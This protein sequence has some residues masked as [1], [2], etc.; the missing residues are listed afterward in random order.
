MNLWTLA[1]LVLLSMAATLALQL[2]TLKHLENEFRR[3]TRFLNGRIEM[4]QQDIIDGIVAQLTKAKNEIVGKLEE[5]T[6][7]VQAQLV[8]AGV[9]DQVDLSALTGIAQALDDLVPDAEVE[10]VVEAVAVETA[11]EAVDEVAVDPVAVDEVAVDPVAVA[12]DEVAVD[13]VAVDE[14]AVDPAE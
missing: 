10:A 3:R 7:G 9:E 12:V 14:V 13:E 5:A 8:A 4:A 11:V 6:S 2:H 1:G